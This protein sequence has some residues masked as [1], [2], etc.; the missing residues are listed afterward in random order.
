MNQLPKAKTSEI[1]VQELENEL[2]VYN[3]K[4]NKAFC[5]NETCGLVFQLCDGTKTVA[6]ISQTLNKHLKQSVNQDLIWLALD[7]F[8]KDDLLEE[9]EQFAINFNGLTRRQVIKKVGIAT[10]I[11][12]PMV[13]SVV[14]PN[15]AM[16]ASGGTVALFGACSTN[17][18]CASG[19]CRPCAAGTIPCPS[20]NW[21]C[22]PGGN[23]G[24]GLVQDGCKPVGGC[25]V[26]ASTCCSG[27]IVTGP[28]KCGVPGT[29]A[30]ICG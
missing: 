23:G 3:L 22:V 7:S 18:E 1:L 6:E 11:A 21:C 13:S 26:E 10:M 8:K 29:E 30:C 20:F 4:T 24:P 14:A 12:L 27:I 17:Q 25:P 9:G 16:A 15:A 2:L 19:S 28:N 5:L